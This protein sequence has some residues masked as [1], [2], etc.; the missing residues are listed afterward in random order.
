[1]CFLSRKGG[2]EPG[3]V[4]HYL[5]ECLNYQDFQVELN[6]KV[7]TSGSLPSVKTLLGEK[8]WFNDVWQYI[9]QTKRDI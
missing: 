8:K 5:F 7:L 6:D 4:N 3:E 1:M 2:C 9:D